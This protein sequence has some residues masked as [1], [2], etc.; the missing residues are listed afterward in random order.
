GAG[1]S[2]FRVRVV[3]RPGRDGGGFGV[4]RRGG[5]NRVLLTNMKNPHNLKNMRVNRVKSARHARPVVAMLAITATAIPALTLAADPASGARWFSLCASCHGDRA[6]GNAAL[7]A[8]RLQG[9]SSAYLLRQLQDF[10]SGRRGS[11]PA[12]RFGQEMRSMAALLPNDAAT[13]DVAAYITG[14]QAPVAAASHG[15]LNSAVA[16]QTCAGCHGR[17]G[18]GN[19]SVG[20]PRLSG[21]DVAYI[22]RQLEG[23]R[24]GWRGAAPGDAPGRQ[25]AAV[26]RALPEPALSQVLALFVAGSEPVAGAK[27]DR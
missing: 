17:A 13:Q 4:P 16:Y 20:A 19:S 27:G 8:P 18:E 22:R 24:R 15:D 21:Q 25:M 11:D 14:L 10:R 26:V 6:E 9:L 7:R 5:G 12:D 23:F 2:S 3:L 1:T